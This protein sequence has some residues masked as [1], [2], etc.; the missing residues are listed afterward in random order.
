MAMPSLRHRPLFKP[1][2]LAS[3]STHPVSP[4]NLLTPHFFS[5][6][7]LQV[8]SLKILSAYFTA[9]VLTAIEGGYDMGPEASHRVI[10]Q[11]GD[12]ETFEEGVVKFATRNVGLMFM[13][14]AST[15]GTAA[16]L[17]KPPARPSNGN[18]SCQGTFFEISMHPR[19][20]G[21]V[22]VV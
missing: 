22:R 3:S 19:V 15:R 16:R 13:K 17:M 9:Q 11:D 10:H 2:V 14:T 5:I 18:L 4:L 1:T 7:L 21:G 20:S 6:R 12:R 8:L